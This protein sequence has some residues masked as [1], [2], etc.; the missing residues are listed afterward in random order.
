MEYFHYKKDKNSLNLDLD[1][2][3]AT[4]VAVLPET[5]T[6]MFRLL[7]ESLFITYADTKLNSIG[8][9]I[10]GFNLPD[11]NPWLLRGDQWCQGLFR[12]PKPKCT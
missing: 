9:M 11:L 2:Y 3:N 8:N 4:I 7:I 12:R 5:S 1:L 6:E 10:R